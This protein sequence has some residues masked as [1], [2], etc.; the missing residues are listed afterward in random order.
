MRT[1]IFLKLSILAVGDARSVDNLQANYNLL[2]LNDEDFA[3]KRKTILKQ[4]LTADEE[5]SLRR[6][7]YS[8]L[9]YVRLYNKMPKEDK[10]TKDELDESIQNWKAG[11]PAELQ[12]LSDEVKTQI[13][14]ERAV[15]AAAAAALE[16]LKITK[17]KVCFFIFEVEN[18]VLILVCRTKVLSLMGHLV[19][20][21][22]A[23]NKNKRYV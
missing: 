1:F 8:R 5:K 11:H 16:R 22:K 12:Q 15:A 23:K 20:E 18:V 9:P 17:R 13:L 7:V 21:P 3:K 2:N 19:K 14:R 10:P 6:R 4:T